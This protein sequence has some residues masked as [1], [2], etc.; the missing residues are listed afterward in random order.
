MIHESTVLFPIISYPWRPC[1]PQG[2]VHPQP[3]DRTPA[4]PR[5]AGALVE[6]GM[7]SL[8]HLSGFVMAGRSVLLSG[9]RIGRRESRLL[10]EAEMKDKTEWGIRRNIHRN[11]Y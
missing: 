6:T 9:G 10:S 4:L 7:V 3:K 8:L 2:A 1:K 5:G 11:I